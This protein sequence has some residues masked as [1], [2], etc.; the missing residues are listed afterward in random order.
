[1]PSPADSGFWGTISLYL[2]HAWRSL[3][4]SVVEIS[5]YYADQITQ[6][7]GLELGFKAWLQSLVLHMK[8]GGDSGWRLPMERRTTNK[9]GDLWHQ[10]HNKAA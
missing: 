10:L 4:R 1:M 5:F 6:K 9:P 7:L 2:L 8:H 3:A